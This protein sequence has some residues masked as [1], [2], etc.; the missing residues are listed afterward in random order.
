VPNSTYVFA[1]LIADLD[2]RAVKKSGL[3]L[4]AHCVLL[5]ARL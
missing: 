1:Q 5:A 2:I 3:P 4:A